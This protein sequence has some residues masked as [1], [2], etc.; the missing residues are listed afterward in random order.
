MTNPSQSIPDD[1]ETLDVCIPNINRAERLKRLTFGLI[2]AAISLVILAVLVIFHVDRW[3][4]LA[5]FP[6]F[7]MAT[8]GY[9][10]WRDKT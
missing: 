2:M 7:A 4:R 6:L 5:L 1:L 3:W 10:Q 8:S 9:F